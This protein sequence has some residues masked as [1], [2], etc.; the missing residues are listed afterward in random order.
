MINQMVGERIKSVLALRNV[1]QTELATGIGLSQDN[2]ISYW[3]SGKRKPNIEQ[4]IQIAKFLDVSSDYLL[5]L[6]DVPTN[7][8]QLKAVCDYIG[9]SEEAI[10]LLHTTINTGANIIGDD[11]GLSKEAVRILKIFLM[12]AKG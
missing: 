1:K 2:T 3:C 10:N 4:I 8:I 11:M 9:L 6:S 5:G 7:D 12:E